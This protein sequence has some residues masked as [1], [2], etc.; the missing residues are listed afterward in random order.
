VDALSG[1]LPQEFAVEG[2]AGVGRDRNLA[3]Q[4]AA[5]GIERGD[6]LA[7]REPDV[8]TV[9]GDAAYLADPGVGAVFADDLRGLG[10]GLARRRVHAARLPNRQRAWE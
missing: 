1:D 2:G 8:R 7:T 6:A 10:P 5:R 3:H 4:R 9:E